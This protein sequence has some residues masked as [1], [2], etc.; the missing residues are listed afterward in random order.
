MTGPG[1]VS[2]RVAD[3]RP[4]QE[5]V[6][7]LFREY[8]AGLGFS[9]D[10]QDF[11]REIREFPGAYA[12]PGGVLLVA[13]LDGRA[14]GC[15]GL[16]PLDP[17]SCEMK[18]L[19]VRPSSRGHGAGRQLAERVINEGRSIGYG[20]MRLDTVPSMAAAI[21]LY[22]TLGFYEIPPYRYNPVPGALYFELRL[23]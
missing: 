10:F 6:K 23:R 5:A 18:R 11:D 15:V 20:R 19:Y 1:S 13:E 9:L 4:S 22:R 12:A 7:E 3:D 21:A 8:A 16:R 2:I 14:M 17:V